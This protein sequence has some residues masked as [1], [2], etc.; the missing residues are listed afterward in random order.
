M[1]LVILAVLSYLIGCIN[2]AYIF[3]KI[4]GVD[5]RTVGS[6]NAGASNVFISIGNLA[7][8]FTALFDIFK[9][10]FCFKMGQHL[11]PEILF[12]GI[13][14]GCCCLLGHIF[15]FYMKFR[16]GK[17]LASFAGIVLANNYKVFLILIFCAVIVAVV[18]NYVC[19]VAA[20]ACASVPITYWIT[21]ND[22]VGTIVVVICSLVILS[23]HIIN[24]KRIHDGTEAH[25][26]GLWHR[27]EEIER[28]QQNKENDNKKAETD[29]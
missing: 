6:E 29:R 19:M 9:S 16:G 13:L 23:R 25:I 14:C 8:V 27:E 22:M 11:V 5:I 12:A 17:G 2:P 10:F 1:R 18:S 4:R 20:F 28:I 3:G 26:S 7:G 21:S 15:P 24:F